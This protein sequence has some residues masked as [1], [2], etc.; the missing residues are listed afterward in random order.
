MP[1]DHVLHPV[2]RLDLAH[3]LGFLGAHAV[4]GVE[5]WDGVTYARSIRLPSRAAVVELWAA[6]G[7][8]LGLRV[9]GA[10]ADD[11]DLLTL[12]RHLTG[13]D[14]DSAPADAH[15]IDDDLLGRLVA[16]RPGLRLPGSVE[17]SET[18]VRTVVGQQVSLAGARR[19]TGRLV[20]MAGEPL[21]EALQGA[22]P[23]VAHLFPSPAALAALESANLPMPRARGRCVVALGR[24]LAEDTTLVV[25]D[26]R[27]LALPG[28]GPWTVAYT[29]LRTRRDPDVF[30]PTDLAVR[31]QLEAM[32][33]PGDVASMMT[34][35]AP[36]APY[37]SVAM[38]HLWAEYLSNRS[39]RV[40]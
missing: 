18:L 7:G 29:R 36:W 34:V 27:L 32:G 19:T 12:V 40:A 2:G 21:P 8:V 37:R 20:G 6:P 16:A 30:L 33:N 4:P 23:G 28:I 1:R 11:P 15:L 10:A 5:A 26:A 31:R 13:L 17:H 14:D 35:S 39:R 9:H 24:A 22:V 38:L 25:D 3:L